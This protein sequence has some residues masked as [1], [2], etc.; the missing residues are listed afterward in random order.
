MLWRR[1]RILFAIVGFPSEIAFLSRTAIIAFF[2]KSLAGLPPNAG[3]NSL[4]IILVCSLRVFSLSDSKWIILKASASSW[5]ITGEIARA[6]CRDRAE[7]SAVG[8]C[9][10]TAIDRE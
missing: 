3:I 2:V 10:A 8:G 9:G 7:E 5:N 4:S 1:V 6:S